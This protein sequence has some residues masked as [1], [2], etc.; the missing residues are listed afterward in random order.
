MS[1]V[2]GSVVFPRPVAWLTR[3]STPRDQWLAAR[4]GGVGGSDLSVILG[5]S[6]FRTAWALWAERAGLIDADPGDAERRDWGSALEAAVAARWAQIEGAQVR[7]VGMVA[8]PGRPWRRAS[9]DR[10]VVA[11]GTRRAVALLECKTTSERSGWDEDDDAIRSRYEAQAQ[12]YLGITGLDSAHLAVLVGG[13]ELRRW[14]VVADPDRY[15]TLTGAAD[16][17]WHDHLLAGSPPP[18]VPADAAWTG[19]LPADPDAPAA[20]LDDPDLALLAAQ[21]DAHKAEEK[22]WKDA[23]DLIDAALK[24]HM[25]AATELLSPD[26]RLLF[27]FR[28]QQSTRLDTARL[29]AEQPAVYEQY[30]VRGTSRVLRA[31]K[32]N[33]DGRTP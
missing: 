10:V 31:K 13:Q 22:F 18:L 25:G 20:V 28:E 1:G 21:R 5:T 14:T 11:P 8:D 33:N 3:A 6:P 32:H 4:R 7:R 9:I 19:R 26:G 12:W 2:R 15:T 16:A 30:A 29:R 17:F 24:A 23:G 27:T